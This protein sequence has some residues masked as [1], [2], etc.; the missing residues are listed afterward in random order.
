MMERAPTRT[1]VGGGVTAVGGGVSAVGGGVTATR[2]Q[3]QER[4]PRPITP[5]KSKIAPPSGY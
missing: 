3:R 1:A 4:P 2:F 5:P